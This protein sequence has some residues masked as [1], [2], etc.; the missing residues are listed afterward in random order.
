LKQ[1]AVDSTQVSADSPVVASENEYFPQPT[2][3]AMNREALMVR[4][5]DGSER[6]SNNLEVIFMAY[7]LT[8]RFNFAAEQVVTICSEGVKTTG[9]DQRSRNL[10]EVRKLGEQTLT[11]LDAL[12][13]SAQAAT[14][15]V[16]TMSKFN[17][18]VR[19]VIQSLNTCQ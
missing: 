4:L 3:G 6:L 9:S 13:N 19:S 5:S 8:S 15:H 16:H 18:Q 1:E 11:D 10:Q 2:S 17:D 14:L 7:L 12:R